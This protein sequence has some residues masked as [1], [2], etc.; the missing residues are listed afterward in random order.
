M[1]LQ[2]S[3]HQN[4]Q[5]QSLRHNLNLKQSQL[6]RLSRNNLLHQMLHQ[7]SQHQNRLQLSQL[8]NLKLNPRQK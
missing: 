4:H 8:Q 7:R 1:P 6:H 5:P 3:L 2:P